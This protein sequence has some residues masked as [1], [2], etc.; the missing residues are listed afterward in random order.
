MSERT[1]LRALAHPLR[2]R[3]LA[4]L[5]V[6]GRATATELAQALDT[7]TGA[8]SYHLRKLA[9]VGL[10][11]DTRSGTGRRRVWRALDLPPTAG[12]VDEPLDEDDAQAADWL[13]LDYLAHFG[14]RAR[15]WLREKDSYEPAWRESCGLEDHPVQV[16]AEQV[17]ALRAELLEVLERYRR[18][19][20]GNPQARRV[21][22][23]TCALPLPPS[24]TGRAAPP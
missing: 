3:L 17:T 15:D 18:V 14:E 24:L 6:H 12:P 11:E 8:T 9:E 10:V 16:T 7:H 20:Q 21:V 5:R 1:A 2:S 22:V 4:E 19:G 23:Y 13:A